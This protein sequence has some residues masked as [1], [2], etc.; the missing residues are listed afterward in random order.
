MKTSVYYLQTLAREGSHY[1]TNTFSVIL[2]PTKGSK[3]SPAAHLG[4]TFPGNSGQAQVQ[5][6]TS[7]MHYPPDDGYELC[8]GQLLGNQKLGFVQERKVFLFMVSLNNYLF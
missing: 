6:Q 8:H 2:P 3:K 4:N 7:S 1:I 5:I